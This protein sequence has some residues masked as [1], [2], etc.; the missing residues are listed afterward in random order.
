MYRSLTRGWLLCLL[1]LLLNACATVE[2]SD[3]S[4]SDREKLEQWRRYQSELATIS[5]WRLRGKMGVKTGPK[6]GSATLKWQYSPEQQRI[7][8][9]GPFGGGRVI[10]AVDDQGAV[11]RDTKG[12]EIRGKRRKCC[13]SDWDGRCLSTISLTG[14]GASPAKELPISLLTDRDDLSKWC[15]ATGK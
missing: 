2:K 14:P 9:Y 15:R 6:G 1:L 5:S 10:I 13:I 4:F 7:E 11:L 3:V 12:E 8:L